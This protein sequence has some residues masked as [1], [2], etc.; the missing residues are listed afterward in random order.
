MSDRAL[1]WVGLGVGVA[2]LAAVL[3]LARKA[4]TVA[5]TAAQAVNPL[6]PQNV[7]SGAAN[8]ATQ[9]V[10]GDPYSTFGT[11][12]WSWLN[13][14]QAA[15]DASITAP[16]NVPGTSTSAPSVLDAPVS[17]SSTDGIDLNAFGNYSP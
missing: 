13:P 12:L 1:V 9:A 7:F 4:A 16:S 15:A 10:T 17:P 8:A 5:T 11:Q 14:A 2:A 6:N 3:L